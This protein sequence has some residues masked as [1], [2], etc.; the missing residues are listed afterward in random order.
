[1]QDHGD[2]RR[3]VDCEKI[4]EVM[5]LRH[6]LCEEL[7]RWASGSEKSGAWSWATGVE[8]RTTVKLNS[9]AFCRFESR[10]FVIY[11]FPACFPKKLK[12]VIGFSIHLNLLAAC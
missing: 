4:V 10:T 3:G 6:H 7:L 9:V 5:Q 11:T 2:G 8:S 12:I 1:M